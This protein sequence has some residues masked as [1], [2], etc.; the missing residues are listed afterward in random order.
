MFGLSLRPNFSLIQ[1]RLFLE[2]VATLELDFD[3]GN[4]FF[5]DE[6]FAALLDMSQPLLTEQLQN[7][8]Y[9]PQVFSQAEIPA[10][11]TTTA[12]PVTT[13]FEMTPKQSQLAP[14]FSFDMEESYESVE[15]FHEAPSSPLD[16]EDRAT[17]RSA[18][19][20]NQSPGPTS[21]RKPAGRR[22]PNIVILEGK[23]VSQSAAPA[24]SASPTPH[25]VPTKVFA[26][27]AA[28]QK[29]LRRRSNNNVAATKSRQKKREVEMSNLQ[30]A[31]VLEEEN[32]K[33][34]GELKKLQTEVEALKG[35]IQSF[36]ASQGKV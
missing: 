24:R 9:Q 2:P 11:T 12:V 7:P 21:Q 34:Q 19:P 5:D 14:H 30:K 20:Q 10:A 36:L 15:H 32:L 26:N 8:T 28:Y 35:V 3:L 18:S 25:D 29:Y 13:F 16:D 6:A 22:K 1:H 27:D 17:S 4:T 33:L 31:T 23:A